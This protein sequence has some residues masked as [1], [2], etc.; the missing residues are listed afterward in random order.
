MH[1]TRQ[2]QDSDPSS[3]PPPFTAPRKQVNRKRQLTGS[4]SNAPRPPCLTPPITLSSPPLRLPATVHYARYQE[5]IVQCEWTASSPAVFDAFC[6]G[7][8]FW[9]M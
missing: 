5:E 6:V 3:P 4:V 9:G 7:V 1:K 2:S 8:A